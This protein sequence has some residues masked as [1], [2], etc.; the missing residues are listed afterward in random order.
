[1]S[2][3]VLRSAIIHTPNK[4][5]EGDLVIQENKIQSIEEKYLGDFDQEINCAGLHVLPGL[6]DTHVHFR[7][8]GMTEKEDFE[9]GTMAAAA[10]GVTTIFDMPNTNPLTI[11]QEALE[12]KN[13]I[14][15]K[16]AKVN[17]NFFVGATKDNLHSLN[18]FK[19][20]AGIKVFVGSSTGNLLL[21]D[22]AD[23]ESLFQNTKHLLAIHA[24]DEEV[25][26]KNNIKFKD[27]HSPEIHSQIRSPEAEINSVKRVLELAKKYN[28]RVHLCHISTEESVNLIEQYALPNVTAEVSMHHLLL[29]EKDYERHQNFVKVNPPLRTEKDNQA[30]WEA[31]HK[32][33]IQTIATDHAPHQAVEKEQEYWQAPGGMPMVELTLP[34]LLNQVSQG[35]ISLHDVLRWTSEKPAEI[36]GIK[37]KG[38]IELG[39]DADLVIIDKEQHHKVEQLNLFTK[40][41]W[42]PFDG[43]ELIGKVI[44]TIVNGEVVFEKGVV[45][46]SVR[47]QKVLENRI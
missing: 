16:K 7:D 6:I 29:N 17:Y 40:C 21:N 14:A 36:F 22:Q 1:M 31:L 32:G 13:K 47:G 2:V 9:T 27:E 41:K 23:L 30:L 34:L 4:I 39:F 33:V 11:N 25:I 43:E 35:K 10:G 42:S 5:I 19:D 38:K 28:T 8:P 44:Y 3:L 26:Q 46:A 37:N 12:E 15:E 20:I 18:D 24:E 45:K